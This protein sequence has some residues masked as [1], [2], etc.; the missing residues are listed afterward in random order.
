M[1]LGRE[2]SGGMVEPRALVALVGNE[3]RAYRDAVVKLLADSRPL[4][5][6]T[7]VEPDDVDREVL[8]LRPHLVICSSLT[9]AVETVPLSWV[10]LYPGG[11]NRSEVSVVGARVVHEEID[12]AGVLS[13]IDETSALIAPDR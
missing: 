8:R 9:P 6:V 10:L 11:E 3:P 13:V 4:V 12:V 7:A 2:R 1:S 5:R